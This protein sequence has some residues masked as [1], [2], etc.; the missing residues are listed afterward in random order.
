M[1]VLFP[2]PLRGVG[3]GAVE[4]L[5]S[6][7]RRAADAHSVS[8]FQFL[9]A[10]TNSHALGNLNGYSESA[11]LVA[12]SIAVLA[13]VPDIAQAT[14]LRFRLVL[15]GNA[16][17]SVVPTRRWCP[18]CIE[19]DVK[20]HEDGYDPLIWTIKPIGMCPWHDCWL[21][22][23]CPHCFSQ[24]RFLPGRFVHRTQCAACM[25]CLG[26]GARHTQPSPAE[27]WN[28]AQLEDLLSHNDG[29]V[30][31]GRAFH[32][33]IR[34][35]RLRTN[36]CTMDLANRLG[37]NPASV[38]IL[39]QSATSHPMLTT[40]LRFSAS[41]QQ[42]LRMILEEPVAA[43]QQVQFPFST[44][45]YAPPEHPRVPRS[46]LWSLRDALRAAA[47]SSPSASPRSVASICRDF[48]V[49]QG[50]ANYEFPQ[51]VS[52]VAARRRDWMT[53]NASR[54]RGAAENVVRAALDGMRVSQLEVSSQKK[55]VAMLMS[56]SGL[57]KRV[58][59]R[60][61]REVMARHAS[62]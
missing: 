57:P 14:L 12:N 15:S 13:G 33:F 23:T 18:Q 42:P 16:I 55:F 62:Q 45:R 11:L 37:C 49:T 30:F 39:N 36:D 9:S 6:Y 2:V 27:L 41:A 48:G 40:A 53:H 35:L 1:K 20:K 50:C 21:E 61:L 56:Q 59:A 8:P 22:S 47:T 7:V 3:T 17:Q 44:P 43:A 58:L 52:A 31:D 10:T 60:A 24:Q 32:L 19:L 34:T 38:H 54:Q 25:G 29:P 4:S 5:S 51:L 26:V 46:I 28:R